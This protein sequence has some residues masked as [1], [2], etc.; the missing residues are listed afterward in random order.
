MVNHFFTGVIDSMDLRNTLKNLSVV[1]IGE[2]IYLAEQELWIKTHPFIVQLEKDEILTGHRG[3]DAKALRSYIKEKV[4]IHIPRDLLY[5]FLTECDRD[6]QLFDVL[7]EILELVNAFSDRREIELHY[8]HYRS[9]AQGSN[10]YLTQYKVF[11]ISKESLEAFLYYCFRNFTFK[12]PKWL[13]LICKEVEPIKT[14]GYDGYHQNFGGIFKTKYYKLYKVLSPALIELHTH[15]LNG[16]TIREKTKRYF[17][18]ESNTPFEIKYNINF[19]EIL[20]EAEE[21]VNETGISLD[22]LR[23]LKARS[24]YECVE[25]LYGDNYESFEL[26]NG[27]RAVMYYRRAEPAEKGYKQNYTKLLKIYS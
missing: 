6:K 27:L 4:G 23:K 21:I 8:E 19:S 3:Q 24:S 20:S 7:E 16:S 5:N 25:S 13:T 10:Y 18:Y 17:K 22:E 1:E 12:I 9:G 14:Y 2:L 15:H 26:E 11:E